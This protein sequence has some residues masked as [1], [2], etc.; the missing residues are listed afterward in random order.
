[1]ILSTYYSVPAGWTWTG[2]YKTDFPISYWQSFSPAACSR[3]PASCQSFLLTKPAT[4]ANN[5]NKSVWAT[6]YNRFGLRFITTLPLTKLPF[7]TNKTPKSPNLHGK[8]AEFGEQSRRICDATNQRK[9]RNI[10]VG[11]N[12]LIMSR[13][14]NNLHRSA[15]FK[16][17]YNMQI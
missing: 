10:E 7:I 5:N 11:V 12:W 6:D 1:M 4:P 16:K 3:L 8:I 2:H 14:R 13:K 17:S 15:L 9:W